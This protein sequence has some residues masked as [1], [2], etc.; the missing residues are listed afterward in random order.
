MA[1]I[2]IRTGFTGVP[3][4]PWISNFYFDGDL[5]DAQNMADTASDFW[6]D[7]Q[8]AMSSLID[9]TQDGVATQLDVATGE[10]TDVASYTPNDGDG[11]GS[12]DMLPASTQLLITWRTGVFAGG[13]EVRGKT[14]V[15]G[16]VASTNDNDG[17]IDEGVVTQ[18]AGYADSLVTEP[19]HSQIVVWSRKN[20]TMQQVT[21]ARI[22]NEWAVLRSRR[23]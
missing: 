13:R 14:F 15:P 22:T 7:A 4:T 5:A 19:G 12:G 23:D 11:S 16:L 8:L 18:F 2:R 21:G 9:W 10:P 6:S 20:G 3:G 1:L 17:T